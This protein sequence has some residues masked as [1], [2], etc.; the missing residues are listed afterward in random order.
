MSAEHKEVGTKG[1][2]VDSSMGNRLCSVYEYRH[3]MRMSNINDTL[4]VVNGTKGV[5]HMTNRNDTGARSYQS[6][7]FR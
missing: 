5:V 3:I 6:L 4:H 1:L 2:H 7:K